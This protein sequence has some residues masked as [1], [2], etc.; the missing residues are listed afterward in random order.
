MKRMKKEYRRVRMFLSA[1]LLLFVLGLPGAALGDYGY[2]SVSLIPMAEDFTFI[3]EIDETDEPLIETDYPFEKAGADAMTVVYRN[4]RNDEAAALTYHYPAGNVTCGYYDDLFVSDRDVCRQIRNKSITPQGRVYI[5]TENKNE[6][7]DWFLVYSLD[8]GQFVEYTEKTFSLGFYGMGEG[9]LLRSILY[10]DG[11]I[12]G[13]FMIKR[14]SAGALSL[15]YDEYGN[16]CC[17]KV[18][19]SSPERITF[20]LDLSTG[21]FGDRSVTELGFEEA[22]MAIPTLA[23]LESVPEIAE[24]VAEVPAEEPVTAEEPDT[25]HFRIL[26]GLTVG[27]A[28]GVTGYYIFRIKKEK[29]EG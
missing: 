27:L 5:H 28:I 4:W 22:D 13:T 19:N 29:A 7:N 25:G 16:I 23:S 1:A 21:L 11:E 20:E 15:G 6:Q 12:F 2:T 17:G 26:G 24:P 3:V 9:G 8:E 14:T 10:K 18:C